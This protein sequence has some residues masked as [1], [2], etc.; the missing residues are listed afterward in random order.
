VSLDPQSLVVPLVVS[1]LAWLLQRSISG[2]DKK[3]D[4]LASDVK[5]LAIKDNEHDRSSVEWRVRLAG[6]EAELNSSKVWREDMG[7]FLR[8]LGF[9]KRDGQP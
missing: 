2:V 4:M 1:V 5:A 9:K 7:G 8:G 6:V 3:L